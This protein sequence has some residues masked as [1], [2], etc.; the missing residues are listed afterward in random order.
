MNRFCPNCKTLLKVQKRVKPFR[1]RVCPI[2]G[3][4]ESYASCLPVPEQRE[5]FSI[6][7]EPDEI[8]KKKEEKEPQIP[9]ELRNI[10]REKK[11]IKSKM[12]EEDKRELER[13]IQRIRDYRRQKSIEKLLKKLRRNKYSGLKGEKIRI[14][15][16]MYEV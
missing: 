7:K 13:Y 15:G 14:G 9:I 12:T 2:C 8:A 11:Y 1:K 10:K 16:E 6:I 3:Y 5:K 4:K